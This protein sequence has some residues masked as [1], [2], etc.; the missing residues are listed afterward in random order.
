MGTTTDVKSNAA[1]RVKEFLEFFKERDDEHIDRTVAEVLEHIYGV[2]NRQELT[3][4]VSDLWQLPKQLRQQLELV[5]GL[6]T[7]PFLDVISKLEFAMTYLGLGEDSSHFARHIVGLA[8]S[9]GMMSATLNMANP[10]VAL[11]EPTR[12]KLVSDLEEILASIAA[13]DDIDDGFK[14]FASQKISLL[15]YALQRY[16]VLGSEAVVEETERLLGSLVRRLPDIKQS[17]QKMDI[18]RK[19]YHAATA[20]MLALNLVNSSF[21]LEAHTVELLEQKPTQSQVQPVK[22]LANQKK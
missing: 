18:A 3:Q 8:D 4:L 16:D 11:S 17:N 1:L 20:V 15:I 14:A 9:F 12:K 22:Q 2:D 6:D 7:T 21:Q 19:L 5:N 10:E 13:A